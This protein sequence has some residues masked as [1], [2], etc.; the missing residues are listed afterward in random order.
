M[1]GVTRITITVKTGG[2]AIDRVVL[3][4]P[5]SVG[6]VAQYS[7]LAQCRDMA[8][9]LE[10]AADAAAIAAS[11]A[12]A[13]RTGAESARDEAVAA[14]A[15]GSA[16]AAQTDNPHQ[17]TKDQVG[18]DQVLNVTQIPAAEKGAADGV[19]TLG[20]DG[21]VA[22]SQLPQMSSAGSDLYLAANLT[23]YFGY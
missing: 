21:K 7:A 16:H 17:V 20:P 19:A 18:L 8:A 1:S 4:E 23:S 13:A 5:K 15:A 9:G 22:A 10:V 3:R 12:V 11:E 6:E 2:P 14:A